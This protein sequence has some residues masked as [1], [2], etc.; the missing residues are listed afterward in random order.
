MSQLGVQTAVL[1]ENHKTKSAVLYRLTQTI[2][3]PKKRTVKSDKTHKNK[4]WKRTIVSKKKK[5]CSSPM[6][7]KH[8]MSIAQQL[9]PVFNT[10]VHKTKRVLLPLMWLNCLC[11]KLKDTNRPQRLGNNECERS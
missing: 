5:S 2:E 9:I 11:Y 4:K 3:A 1:S 8:S 7:F 6:W 10:T